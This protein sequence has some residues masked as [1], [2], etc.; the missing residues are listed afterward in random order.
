MLCAGGKL[1]EDSCQG[2]SGGPL[3]VESNGSVQLVGVVSWGVGCGN[4]GNP[5]VYSRISIARDF[6]EPFITTSPATGSNTTN[7]SASPMTPTAVPIT[8]TPTM[9]PITT[10]EVPITT[11]PTMAPITT[12][13]V[14]TV[15][16]TVTHSACS[17]TPTAV[18]INPTPTM[19][20]I[21]TAEV[22]TVAPT[23]TPT[24]ASPSKCNGCSTCFYPTLNHCFPPA[25][26][27]PTCATFA[28]LGAFWCG[29]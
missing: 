9:A 3:T 4:L 24:T 26:T 17:T 21:T 1:G 10:A 6:I 19:A 23:V 13:E 27:K 7:H 22:P 20:P 2:D 5:G 15:A 28:S 8:T 16:P 12:A 11:T 29:N 14:P 18:P 25:Y